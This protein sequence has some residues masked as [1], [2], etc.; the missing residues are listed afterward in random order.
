[1]QITTFYWNETNGKWKPGPDMHH[2]RFV[3]AAAVHNST[4]M[5]VTGGGTWDYGAGKPQYI[6]ASATVEYYDTTN[7]TPSWVLLENAM[8]VK[9]A[10]HGAAIVGNIL[11]IIGGQDEHYKYLTS[12]ETYDIATGVW[13][14]GIPLKTAR[15]QFATAVFSD[16]IYIIGGMRSLGDTATM[17]TCDMFDPAKPEGGWTRITND[18][19]AHLYNCKAVVV[20]NS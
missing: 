1:M 20:Q 9:R 7:S 11:Y 3:A 18:I 5:F 10:Q 2:H 19:G 14:T 17:S 6:P 13:D 8:K 12:V 4:R 15:S 16:K